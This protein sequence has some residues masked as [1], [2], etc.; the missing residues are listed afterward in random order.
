M[1]SVSLLS[2]AI[3]TGT[4]LGQASINNT[5]VEDSTNFCKINKDEVIGYTCDVTFKEINEINNKIRPE[6]VS[7]VHSDFFKYFKLNLYKQCPFWNDNNGY[8]VNRACAVDV[9]EDWDKLAS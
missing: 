8:C 5:T 4:A 2:A 9:I 3:L 6:L 1:R 7:L